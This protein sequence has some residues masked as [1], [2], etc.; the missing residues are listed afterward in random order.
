MGGSV[1]VRVGIGVI[2]IVALTLPEELPCFFPVGA[3]GCSDFD[4]LSA[5][6][7]ISTSSAEAV[8]GGKLFL[9][10]TFLRGKTSY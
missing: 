5:V 3:G 8:V 9:F 2:V 7:V 6:F 4:L 1:W 10:D